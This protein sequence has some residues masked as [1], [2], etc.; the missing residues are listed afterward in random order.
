[1]GTR[2]VTAVIQSEQFKI[3][4]Y[5][6]WDGYPE[7]QGTNIL[8]FLRKSNLD[9]FKEQVAKCCFISEEEIKQRWIECGADPDD[10]W[11]GMDV[12]T[13]FKK[14][15]PGLSRD[16]GSDILSMVYNGETFELQNSIDFVEDSLWCE[17]AYVIDLDKNTFEVFEGFNKKPL[18]EN[19]RF[20][21]GGTVQEKN[22]GEYY[23]VKLVKSY[24]LD[25]LPT[26]AKFLKEINK[27]IKRDD[28]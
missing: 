15:Y 25:K 12:A 13:K 11:V 14:K 4:Q 3:A 10:E 19:E 24:S 7:G 9:K 1:M 26:K 27:L 2:H 18:N 6:Q 21:N 28:E 5:G 17:W 22:T 8:N 23:P 20:F 16:I